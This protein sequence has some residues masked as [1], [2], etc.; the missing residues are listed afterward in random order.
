MK[1]PIKGRSGAQEIRSLYSHR[2]LRVVSTRCV[3]IRVEGEGMHVLLGIN[4]MQL[5]DLLQGQPVDP[6]FYP[7]SKQGSNKHLGMD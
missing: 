5:G 4:S 7:D 6:P 1:K 3:C 2:L